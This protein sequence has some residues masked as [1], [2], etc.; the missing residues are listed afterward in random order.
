MSRL[1]QLEVDPLMAERLNSASAQ[2]RY[3]PFTDEVIDWSVPLTEE[4]SYM[5]MEHSVFAG[6]SILEGL[7]PGERAFVERWEMTQLMRNIGHG[8]HMLNQGILAMLW[9]TD[10]LD[11]SYRYLLHEVAEEC[12]HMAMF[13][14]WVRINDDIVAAGVDEA[15]WGQPAAAAAEVTARELPAAF[16]VRVL[17]FEFVGDDLNQSMRLGASVGLHPILVQ[18]GKVH[19]AEEARH[20]SYARS[21]LENGIGKLTADQRAEVQRTTR[22]NAQPLI[23]RKALLP[24]SWS[25]Q[26]APFMSQ[27]V[28]TKARS[29]SGARART[30][31]QLKY[32]LDEFEEIG[33]ID[34]ATMRTWESDGAFG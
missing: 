4:W 32:L 3:F 19:T 7:S 21:W 13:N 22:E 27:D 23:D 34:S 14:H 11:P 33:A 9:I 2:R 30:M 29:Q 8:E 31:V 24:V 26:L 16:W 10:P 28:F 5:P 25:D 17:L 15:E 1:L 20:I 18:I 12:Q 6:S